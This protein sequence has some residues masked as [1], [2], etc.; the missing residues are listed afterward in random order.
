MVK[1]IH[2]LPL[3]FFLVFN[4]M[5]LLQAWKK[6]VIQSPVV[7]V[8]R[9]YWKVFFNEE[10]YTI[11]YRWE[12]LVFLKKNL[13]K[14][15]PRKHFPLKIWVWCVQKKEMFNPFAFVDDEKYLETLRLWKER[16]MKKFLSRHY[17]PKGYRHEKIYTYK[18]PIR[19]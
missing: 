6:Q 7:R 16:K 19:C 8:M 11:G 17:I 18:R 15:L 1:T 12:R 5:S 3:F 9:I 10:H 14:K 2:L 4:K 13:K